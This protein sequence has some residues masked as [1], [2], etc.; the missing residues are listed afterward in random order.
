MKKEIRL[1][2]LAILTVALSIW[3]YKF[4]LGKNVFSNTK[5]LT[6]KFSDVSG[7]EVASPVMVS[8]YIVGGVLSF[9]IDPENVR[10]VI[11]EFDVEG[12]IDLPANTMALLK[13]YGV[14][15]D[16]VIELKFDQLCGD[17]VP[18]LENGMEVKG[19][20]FGLL[21]SLIPKEEIDGY[22]QQ[23]GPGIDTVLNKF[24]NIDED[25][26]MGATIQNLEQSMANLNSITM[27]I[28]RMLGNT[29]SSVNSTMKNLDAISA[30]LASNN[31]IINQLLVNL[32]TASKDFKNLQLSET[33]GSTN[34]TMK[35]AN[36]A[37]VELKNLVSNTQ[38]S[39][40]TLEDILKKVDSGEGSMSKLINNGDLYDNLN[41]TSSN[42]NYL[43][44]DL[45]LNPKRYINVSVFGNKKKS[46]PYEV[47]E[48]DPAQ[49]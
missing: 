1:G 28:D 49:N 32:E 37:V 13:N 9:N 15:G 27:K 6:A 16:R 40:T 25:S 10:N 38:T 34:T 2:I 26:K 21:G 17:G 20:S 41:E 12:N 44:Q 5:V 19:Q 45:R 7:L 4:L 11:V 42:L 8:G 43:L 24:N 36:E 14:M 3:G 35:S 46:R 29:M 22:V 23:I 18:C 39:I 33:I 47:P 48:D 30:N 31:Q